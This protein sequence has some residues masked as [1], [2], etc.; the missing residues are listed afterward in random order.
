MT[1]GMKIYAGILLTIILGFIVNWMWVPG[2][3]RAINSKLSADEYLADYPYHFRVL[4]IDGSTAFVTTP[5]SPIVP[6]PKMIKAIDPDL[7]GVSIS[8]DAYI[9]AQQGLAD[10]QAHAAGIIMQS[11]GIK[12]I[13]WELDRSWL[14]AN[15]IQWIE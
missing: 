13:S 11:S 7:E 9:E 15:G 4:R 14:R 8:S 6:V 2:D 5:R 1:T 3:V 10:R 12:Q